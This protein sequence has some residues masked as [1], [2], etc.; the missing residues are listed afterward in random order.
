MTCFLINLPFYFTAQPP[1]GQP[2][3]P[4]FA[5]PQGYAQPQQPGGYPAMQQNTVVVNQPTT[6]VVQQFRDT[7]VQ[8]TCP[9]CQAQVITGINYISGTFTWLLCIVIFLIG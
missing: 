2:P 1:Y 5:P 6:M 7:P 8:T 3:P 4:G 9:H